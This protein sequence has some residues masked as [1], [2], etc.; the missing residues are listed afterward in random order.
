MDFYLHCTITDNIGNHCLHGATAKGIL[1]LV[2][3][4]QAAGGDQNVENNA[5]VRPIHVAARTG[6]IVILRHYIKNGVE[7]D[8]QDNA[9]NTALHLASLCGFHLICITLID[10]NADSGMTNGAGKAPKDLCMN[11]DTAAVF[12]A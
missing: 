11:D 6:Q 8:A 4:I 1:G 7:V 10:A 12:A 3:A 9:G 2:Q 5:K